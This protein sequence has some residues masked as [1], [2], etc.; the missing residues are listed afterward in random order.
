MTVQT[1]EDVRVAVR[2]PRWLHEDVEKCAELSGWDLSKQIRHEL[3]WI[4]GK[5]KTPYLPQL[6]SSDKAPRKG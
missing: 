1:T 5:A 6:P 2:L 4:R 3:S